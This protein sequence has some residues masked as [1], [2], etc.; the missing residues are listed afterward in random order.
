MDVQSDLD[1]I[2][3]VAGIFRLIVVSVRNFFSQDS[4]EAVLHFYPVWVPLNDRIQSQL[5]ALNDLELDMIDDL[6][7][8]VG[9]RHG[10]ELKIEL[11]DHGIWFMTMSPI[12]PDFDPGPDDDDDSDPRPE[13]EEPKILKAMAAGTH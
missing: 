12:P 11:D 5:N 2:V 4:E 1:S 3:K 10:K 13:Y 7:E 8:A 6:F 9:L